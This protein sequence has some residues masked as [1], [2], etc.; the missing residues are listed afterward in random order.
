MDDYFDM[1]DDVGTY[2]IV[3]QTEHFYPSHV[4]RS[5]DSVLRKFFEDTIVSSQ[6]LDKFKSTKDE[7]NKA[8]FSAWTSG[9][10]WRHVMSD[11]HYMIH[12]DKQM[13]EIFDSLDVQTFSYY[14][15]KLILNQ[16]TRRKLTIV[17]YGEGK[18]TELDV[19]CIININQLDQTKTSAKSLC[20]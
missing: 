15:Y 19:D 2:Q 14:Y 13:S 16:D 11:Y 10:L 4:L 5:I 1:Y 18:K 7:L 6:F 12:L 3:L 9:V 8:P 20:V 17:M